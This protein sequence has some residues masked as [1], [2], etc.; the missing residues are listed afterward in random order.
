MSKKILKLSVLLIISSIFLSGCTLPWKKKAASVN[1]DQAALNEQTANGSTTVF[2]KQLKKFLNNDELKTFLQNHNNLNNFSSNSSAGSV[3]NSPLANYRADSYGSSVPDIIKISADYTYSLVRNELL[4]IKSRPA[5]EARIISRIPFK[6]RPQNIL[7]SGNSVLVYGTDEEINSNSISK[8]FRRQNPYTFLKVYDVS[9]P[10]SPK[11]VRDLEFEGTYSNAR[12][13]GDYVYF[14]TNT[15]G[16]YFDG[17]PLLPRVLSNGELLNTTCEAGDSSCEVP[18]T[19]YFDVAYNYFNFV[20][21]SAINVKNNDEAINRQT[22][23]L[24]SNQDIYVSPSNIYITY[25]DSVDEYSLEQ[26]AKREIILSKLNADDQSKIAKIDEAPDFILNNNEKKLK[27]GLVVDNYLSS[28][29]VDDRAV[30]QA[31]IDDSVSKKISEQSNGVDKTS[32]YRFSMASKMSYEAIGEVNGQIIDKYSMDE[33]NGY[34]RIATV[35]K[36]G[37]VIEGASSSDYFSNLY[38]LGSDLKVAGSLENLATAAPI[39]AARFTGNR[40]Y[41]STAKTDDPLYIIDLSDSTKLSVLGAV[42]VSANYSYLLPFDQNGNK[43]ISFGKE[44][45]LNN[46]AEGVPAKGLRLSLFDFSDLQKPK[47]LDNYMIGNEFSDS[48]ALSDQSTF[49]YSY[50]DN[51]NFLIIPVSL[52]EKGNLSFAGSFVFSFVDGHLVLKGKVD[53]SYGGH[54]TDSDSF[55]GF[56]Y[57][58]NTVRRGLYSN[59]SEDAVYTFSNKF[60]KINKLADLSS[61]KDLI[62]T[63][64]SDDYIMTQPA[65]DVVPAAPSPAASSDNANIP[66]P[67]PNTDLTASSTLPILPVPPVPPVGAPTTTPGSTSTSTP[68]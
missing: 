10:I 24:N 44:T 16:T 61:V 32:I 47:E 46:N 6:S 59:D 55:N 35:L 28:L 43:L 63:T 50:S 12:L 9:D 30:V 51:K 7:V 40:A 8:T 68:L 53:H 49:S 22:Y 64:G 45:G 42:K 2:T 37:S 54:F 39:N 14:L 23:L 26:A 13:V 5:S 36:P 27:V 52:R 62:L 38:I 60:L 1:P 4:I 41:F 66:V 58:D 67:A 57:Y 3:S 18:E 25:A 17:E 33:D 15:P 11:L 21:I 31:S 19:Y 56:N 65:N 48:I 20:N 29:S 34:L